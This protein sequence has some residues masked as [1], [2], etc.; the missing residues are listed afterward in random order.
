M[1]PEPL[2]CAGAGTWGAGALLAAADDAGWTS[3]VAAGDP[4]AA[5]AIAS[6][7]AQK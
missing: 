3:D 1:K 7:M 6:G 5:M 2:S 4:D